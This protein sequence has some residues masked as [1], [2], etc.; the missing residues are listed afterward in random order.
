MPSTE[1]AYVLLVL[2]TSVA[3][4][5]DLGGCDRVGL[6]KETITPIS[7]GGARMEHCNTALKYGLWSVGETELNLASIG[8]VC[9]CRALIYSNNSRTGR[10]LTCPAALSPIL[11][12]G[13]ILEAAF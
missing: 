1:A 3:S 2:F 4:R 5:C 11:S 9:F 6:G 10:S 7:A 12:A 13:R 8:T